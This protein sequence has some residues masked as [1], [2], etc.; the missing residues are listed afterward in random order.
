[1][2]RRAVRTG[3]GHAHAQ[4]R[5]DELKRGT[6]S[7]L[8]RWETMEARSEMAPETAIPAQQHERSSRPGADIL[9]G[10]ILGL[11]AVI[12]IGSGVYVGVQQGWVWGTTTALI[13]AGVLYFVAAAGVC[14]T[15]APKLT[16]LEFL[17]QHYPRLSLTGVTGQDGLAGFKYN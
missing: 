3:A 12:V 7:R 9:T 16:G 17:D 15:C 13:V 2:N 4:A 8:E 1:M 14:S 5:I 11:A 6:A 10:V